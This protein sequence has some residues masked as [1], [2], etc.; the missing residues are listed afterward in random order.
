M[1]QEL[2]TLLGGFA[3]VA[4]FCAWLIRAIITHFL[5]KDVESYKEKLRLENSIEL[6]KLRSS[7][8]KEALEH[9]VKFRRIDEQIAERLATVYELIFGLFQKTHDYVSPAGNEGDKTREEKQELFEKASEEFW[10]YFSR[11]RIFIPPRMYEQIKEVAHALSKIG[12]DFT[13]GQYLKEKGLAEKGGVGYWITA[14]NAIRDTATPLF[15]KLVAEHQRRLGVVD[16]DDLS[17][18]E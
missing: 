5:S 13:E 16:V 12:L 1:F 10:T 7:L 3:I 8:A 2:I 9:E 6:E 15:N 4:G 11:N 14:W 18:G 17:A